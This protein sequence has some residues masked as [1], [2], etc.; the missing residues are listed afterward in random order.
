VSP[1]SKSRYDPIDEANRRLLDALAEL[2]EARQIH[3]AFMSL[4][5]ELSHGAGPSVLLNIIA[6]AVRSLFPDAYFLVQLT[7]HR[8]GRHI[9]T[10]Y[11]G[12]LRRGAAERIHLTLSAVK[13]TRIGNDTI[14]QSGLEVSDELP[15]LFEGS[16]YAI[17]AP[18]VSEGQLFGVIHVEAPEAIPLADDE[19]VLLISLAN[20]M[21]LALRN[22]RLL[23]ETA[24]LKDY[25]EEILEQANALI[26]VTDQDRRILVFNR[27][28]ERLLGFEK[29]EILGTDLFRWLPPGDCEKLAEEIRRVANGGGST[30][31]IEVR[32][33]NRQGELV[34]LVFYPAALR[35][36]DQQVSS[37]IL[38][39]QD[40]T[41]LRALEKQVL[42]AEKMASMGKLAAGVVHELNNPLTSISIY[43]EYLA[44]KLACGQV[45]PADA[46]KAQKIL[47]GA[48]RIQKLTRDLVSYSRPASDEAELLNFN[49]V[50]E[51]GLSFCEHIISK[52]DISLNRELGQ[53]IGLVV[54]NRNR[55]LQVVVNLVTN[56]CQAMEAGG[57]LSINTRLQDDWV[58]LSVS[59]T[60]CG[61]PEKD[62]ERI[63]EPF[64]TTKKA[65]EGTGLGLSIVSSIVEHHQGSIRVKS[66]VG[67]GTT[68]EVW[69]PIAR[70]DVGGR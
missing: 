60:G 70:G 1:K 2:K 49:E 58:V 38:V 37:I 39:G 67:A 20:Q 43:A 33:R 66:Q 64:F 52:A 13:K 55:L 51:Q 7:E 26:T 32:M 57:E 27:A 19:E 59:D 53:N 45:E 11:E 21:T 46:A 14:L 30:G 56:A 6:D 4:G 3:K 69:L 41:Q 68:F 24:E 16:S 35:D 34:N 15:L 44:Q 8:P 17:H 36:R 18:L 23:D 5:K 25:L 48:R 63:F 22:Q 9:S 28:M 61:I 10:T 40:L 65:G 42:E 12:P 54:G 62:L 47:E 29:K 31:G 50:V